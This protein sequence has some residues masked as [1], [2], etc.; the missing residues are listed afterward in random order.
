MMGKCAVNCTW[1]EPTVEPLAT[2]SERPL[3]RAGSEERLRSLIQLSSDWYWET[4]TSHRFRGVA[5][6]RG[7]VAQAEP[8]GKGWWELQGFDDA[9]P[10]WLRQ[11]EV[12]QRHEAFHELEVTLANVGGRRRHALISGEPVFCTAGTFSGYRG[13]GHD[14]TAQKEAEQALNA[15]EAQLAAIIDATTDAIIT[16]DAQGRIVVFNTC[17]SQM[18]GC[19]RAQ[20]LGTSLEDYWPRAMH[21]I[22]APQD[23]SLL[24][25]HAPR[26]L[27][28][29]LQTTARRGEDGE[30]F[31]V[32]ATISR[33]DV[34][35]RLL[36]CVV[37]RDLTE[38]NAAEQARQ[39][40]EAQLRE[41]QK[42]EALGTM[43]GG[44][45]HDFNNIVA[46]IL[47]NAALARDSLGDSDRAQVF[48]SEI[49]KAGLRA[50]D[51]VQRI[52][53]FSRK[54][55]AVFSCQPLQPL[56]EESVQLL[57]A[58]LP[59]G[60]E[61]LAQLAP[62]PIYAR[63]DGSQISQIVMNLGTN[64]WQALGSQPGVIRVVLE[65]SEN[66]ARLAISDT[67]CG[68]DEATLQCMFEPFFTTKAKGEGTGLGLSVVHGIVSSH[69]GR[70]EVASRKGEGTTIEIFLPLAAAPES[71][72]AREAPLAQTSTVAG[73]GQH[74]LYL[75]DYPAIVFMM[76]TTLEAR[77]Y[78]VSGFEDAAKA[79][80]YLRANAQDVDLVVTDH[81]MPGQCGLEL[82]GEIRRQRPELP[83]VLASGYI[84]D[85]LR[86]GAQQVGVQH[87]FEKARGIEEM[88]E[89]VGQILNGPVQPA[90]VQSQS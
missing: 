33:I 45:A 79:M 61:V 65:C 13:V 6:S 37:L 50:R 27:V 28:R 67:G 87:L 59:S 55:P 26:V 42:M 31:S 8:L 49:N 5:R 68:M 4:D 89:L 85:E 86:D 83:V 62:E 20:A 54:Q 12:L 43:A 64:A 58:M 66:E 71:D 32:E 56:V 19:S 51:L 14:I 76:K 2:S 41:S 46:A 90:Q 48:V 21:F 73:R 77:G 53:A 82:A 7:T 70:I 16:V 11:L 80:E 84:T 38:R 75:D 30:E 34:N 44:I 88:C 1:L 40:L 22:P 18:F 78:R 60:I 29:A 81:N 3:R 10:A 25:A 63:T 15:S 36:Y 74:V 72:T 9:D 17:A 47:G 35:G 52:M 24:A 39:A 57:R 69:G 23:D